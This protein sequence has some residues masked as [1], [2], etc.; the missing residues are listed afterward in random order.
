MRIVV[1]GCGRLGSALAAG[2]LAAGHR[3]AGIRRA[4]RVEPAAWD[5]VVGDG[6]E[7][8]TWNRIAGCLGGVTV[9]LVVCTANPG[10][11]TGEDRRV[12]AALELAR[13]HHP[14]AGCICTSSTGIYAADADGPVSED[15][16]LADDRRGRRLAAI[17]DAACA[18]APAWILRLG[19]LVGPGRERVA[20]RV[21]AGA[22][23]RLRT[24]ADAPFNHCPEAVA[25]EVLR[26]CIE[27]RLPSGTWNVVAPDP[28][29]TGDRYR[30]CAARLG[31]PCP[32]LV[33]GVGGRLVDG[34]RL[35]AALPELEWGS[36]AE[37]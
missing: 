18:F 36:R 11:R 22:P 1:L 24:R 4:P 26:R 33:D 2:S 28:P 14:R 15:G 35:H 34:A 8:E 17:E 29:T 9:D 12:D 7:P 32:A 21:R 6:A 27:G 3:V 16:P 5:E 13:V 20:E 10:L 31:L 30:A 25:T 37:G 23:I 19:G